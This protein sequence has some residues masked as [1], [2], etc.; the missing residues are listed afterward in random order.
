MWRGRS[1]LLAV[2]A[3]HLALSL[4]FVNWSLLTNGSIGDV[5][6]RLVGRLA[7]P[8][9]IAPWLWIGQRWAWRMLIGVFALWALAELIECALHWQVLS[10][11]WQSWDVQ[12]A[13]L[14]AVGY[15]LLCLWVCLSPGL[16]RLSRVSGR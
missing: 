1:E 10:K 15:A 6:F 9:A 13:L 14:L 7:I 5:V 11:G 8:V 4:S 12:S 3:V 16:R 2:L